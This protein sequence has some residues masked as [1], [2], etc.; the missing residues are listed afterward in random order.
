MRE[1]V[2]IPPSPFPWLFW[3]P[4][5]LNSKRPPASPRAHR[6]GRGPSILAWPSP[7]RAGPRASYLRPGPARPLETPKDK[8]EKKIYRPELGRGPPIYGSARPLETPKDKDEKKLY[9][10]RR[11]HSLKRKYA[12]FSMK[13]ISTLFFQVLFGSHTKKKNCKEKL[14]SYICLSYKKY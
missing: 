14:F 1:G 10:V 7:A 6:P 8:D 11:I 5:W 9:Q 4:F 12:F 13:L 3:K 2:R